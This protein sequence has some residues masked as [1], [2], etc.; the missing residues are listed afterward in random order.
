MGN[1]V[2]SYL[3]EVPG[4]PTLIY[5]NANNQSAGPSRKLTPPGW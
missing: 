1:S 2:P 4:R 5:A 3:T